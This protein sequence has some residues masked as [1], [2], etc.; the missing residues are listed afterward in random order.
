MATTPDRSI[1]QMFLNTYD[2]KAA[3]TF[4]HHSEATPDNLQLAH[5]EVVMEQLHN[6]GCYLLL[7]DTSEMTWPGNEPVPGLGPIGTGASGLQGFHLHSVLALRWRWEAE[8]TGRWPGRPAVEV[9]GLPMQHYHVREPRPKGEPA[10]N[11]K[12]LKYR[13][14]E[15]QWWEQAGEAIGSAPVDE[16]IEWTRVCDRGADIYE[17]LVSCKELNHRFVI[18]A[19]QDRCLTDEQGR[20]VTG[21]LFLTARTQAS[22]G[23]F[24]LELRA[25]P[26]QGA[27]I[28]QLRVSAVEV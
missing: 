13:A 15:S 23:E 8:E 22:L 24:E 25:R 11:S 7:E 9:L 26:G 28:A 19:S 4:F 1:P 6:C 5:R 17:L 10:N 16:R 12:V 20:V 2:I 14:R 18:R 21:K 27:R 3:Y